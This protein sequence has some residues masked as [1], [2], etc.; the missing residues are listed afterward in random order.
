MG[1]GAAMRVIILVAVIRAHGF[2]RPP[3]IRARR[4]ITGHYYA[5]NIHRT[6]APRAPAF[7]RVRQ[8]AKV[9]GARYEI[10]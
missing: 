7:S 6:H 2:T 10:L 3:E 8:Q 1:I 4:F 5:D 9:S